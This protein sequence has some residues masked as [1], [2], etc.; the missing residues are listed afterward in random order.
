MDQLLHKLLLQI[1]K[2][3]DRRY[4]ISKKYSKVGNRRTGPAGASPDN[5]V[6]KQKIDLE[7]FGQIPNFQYLTDLDGYIIGKNPYYKKHIEK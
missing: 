6:P 5:R 4:I 7:I 2:L 3:W 1:W